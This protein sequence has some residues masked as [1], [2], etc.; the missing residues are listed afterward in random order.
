MDWVSA[1]EE[2]EGKAKKEEEEKRKS[3]GKTSK[4]KGKGTKGLPIKA[5][6]YAQLLEAN[7][8]LEKERKKERSSRKRDSRRS[9]L[10][11]TLKRR[12]SEFDSNTIKDYDDIDEDL[13]LASPPSKYVAKPKQGTPMDAE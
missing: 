6:L 5:P 11:K 12:A 7:K 1:S 2:E 13:L 4:N 3:K 8:D 10:D 9:G